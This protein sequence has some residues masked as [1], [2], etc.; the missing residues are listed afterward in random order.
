MQSRA[1]R[2]EFQN[3]LRKIIGNGESTSVWFD[4]WVDA[5]PLYRLYGDCP[6]FAANLPEDAKVSC[7]IKE[8]SWEAEENERQEEIVSLAQNL[9]IRN[10]E[11]DLLVYGEA[12]RKDWSAKAARELF[13]QRRMTQDCKK[14]LWFKKCIP[15]FSFATWVAFLN[16][17][18]T[19]DRMRRWGINTND[20]CVLCKTEQESRDH[21]LF[22]CRFVREIWKEGVKLT[23][24]P[25]ITVKWAEVLNYMH[26]ISSQEELRHLIMKLHW[27]STTYRVWNERNSRRHGGEE[28]SSDQVFNRVKLDIRHRCM[29]LRGCKDTVMNRQICD[30]WG[31]TLDLL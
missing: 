20:I 18:P 17:L 1:S 25:L 2:G 9:M 12:R 21:L 15:R 10:G 8:G 13:V 28:E 16:K 23:C 19:M 6:W 26:Q 11:P 14:L 24:T 29:S 31:L 27:T 22:E 3:H 5:G 4:W 30:N 7:L